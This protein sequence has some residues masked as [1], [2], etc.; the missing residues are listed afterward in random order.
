[1]K[2]FKNLALLVLFTLASL[3]A[4]FAQV[5]IISTVQ[6][7]D[8]IKNNK[9]LVIIDA[10][11]SKN[12]DKAHVKDAIGIQHTDLYMDKATHP[13]GILM[14]PSDIAAYFGKLGINE[15]SEIVIYDEGTQKYSGRL[16]Y[17]LKY[18]G[19][20]NVKLTHKDDKEWAKNRIMLTAAKPKAK[21]AVTFTPS[22]NKNMMASLDY[23]K[24]NLGKPNFV[25]VDTRDANEF[26]GEKEV[27]PGIFGRIPNTINIPYAEFENDGGSFKSKA[28]LEVL[29]KKYGLGADKE[30]VLFCR[31]GVKGSVAFI[32]MHNVLGHK[33]VK[34]FDG[35]TVEYSSKYDLVK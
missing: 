14:N 7:R 32:A 9:E 27:V 20:K 19:A 33:N 23:V 4:A 34:L 1:M 2:S 3:T 15:N 6:F 11:R 18:I 5:D 26:S 12:Y 22:V 29:A 17:I 8:L 35:G 31:T 10:S 16:Y 25:F 30:V 28:D 24:N 13:E 21:A